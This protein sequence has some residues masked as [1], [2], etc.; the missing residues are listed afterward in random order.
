M[1]SLGFDDMCSMVQFRHGLRNDLL[2][3]NNYCWH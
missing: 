2:A 3:A 1:G